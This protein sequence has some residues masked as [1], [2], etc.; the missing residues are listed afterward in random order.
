MLLGAVAPK[1]EQRSGNYGLA[2]LSSLGRYVGLPV[3]VGF[4]AGAR[5]HSHQPPS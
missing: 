4:A 3:S 2:A 5:L 1:R